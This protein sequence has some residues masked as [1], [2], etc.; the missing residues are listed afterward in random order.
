MSK[1][2]LV[3]VTALLAGCVASSRH[4]VGP[5]DAPGACGSCTVGAVIDCPPDCD[6]G[7]TCTFV[8]SDPVLGDCVVTVECDG[9]TCRIVS[10]EPL[11]PGETPPAGARRIEGCP[12]C[13]GPCGD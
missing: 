13:A 4:S 9:D 6:P 12:P 2:I 3:L 11:A 7:E 1:S 10:C 5:A 8:C